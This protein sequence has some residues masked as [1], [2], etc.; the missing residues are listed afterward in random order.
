LPLNIQLL[1]RLVQLA[2]AGSLLV[3]CDSGSDDAGGPPM[4][5]MGGRGPVPVTAVVAQAV[6]FTDSFTAL[7]DARANES[8]EIIARISSVVTGIHF[9]E[10]Q[11]VAKGDLLVSLDAA[12]ITAQLAV[13]R[14][15]RDKLKSQYERSQSLA[16]TRV[17]SE[18]ELDQ[19]AADVR[20]AEADVRAVQAR[21]DQYSI[22]AP[23]TG[24]LGLRHVSLGALV[25]TD[26]LITTLDDTSIIKVQ[27]SMP[28]VF[29][30]S[31]TQGMEV[32]ASSEVYPEQRFPGVIVSLDSRIDP[33]TRSIAVVAEVQNPERLLRPGMFI[34][35]ALQR[36]RDSVMLIPEQAL[37]PRGGRQYIYVVNEGV[38]EEREITLG[39]RAP[40]RVE[41]SDGLKAGEQVVIEG[42]QKIRPGAQVT[43]TQVSG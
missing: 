28:E 37:A 11:Q 35:V 15:Q 6:R 7:G 40:G 3:A 25:G 19:L 33:M 38:V 4:G 29:L 39:V 23:I 9:T 34:T 22:R 24:V 16:K 26:T 13:A 14:A 42:V 36:S 12:E 30:A 8:V 20:G 27:F 32:D 41:I 43:V 21:L 2:L 17:V 5:M 18:S 1:L 31:I 10:G